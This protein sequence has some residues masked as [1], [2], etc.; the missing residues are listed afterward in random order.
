MTIG[1]ETGRTGEA[2]GISSVDEDHK[3]VV[4]LY[5]GVVC[6]ID[7]KLGKQVLLESLG[8]LTASVTAHFAN[9]EKVMEEL[10]CDDAM[11]HKD[12]HNKFVQDLAD[13]RTNVEKSYCEEDWPAI[14]RY[15]KYRFTQHAQI[16]DKRLF[17]RRRSAGDA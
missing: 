17:P 6:A 8:N 15:L 4:R 1:H 2:T 10:G 16:Y 13:F 11:A 14:A 12:D 9:E 7:E 3:Q 5:S